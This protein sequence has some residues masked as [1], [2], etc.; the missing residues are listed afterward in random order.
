MTVRLNTLGRLQ[1][2]RGSEELASYSVRGT[3]CAL[4]LHIVLLVS[5]F[6][7]VLIRTWF[8]G[9]PGK[10]ATSLLEWWMLAAVGLVWIAVSL[11]VLVS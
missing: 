1:V 11:L 6:H 10:H 8:H 4:L 5:A 9:K 3:R 7:A 2:F